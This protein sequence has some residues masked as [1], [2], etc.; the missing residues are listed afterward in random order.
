MKS[1]NK[2][3]K[4]VIFVFMIGILSY[5]YTLNNNNLKLVTHKTIGSIESI[6]F[7]Q[8]NKG[9]EGDNEVKFAM[10]DSM[11]N[12]ELRNVNVH[13]YRGYA[14]Y[15]PS[16]VTHADE[17][18]NIVKSVDSSLKID[19]YVITDEAGKV[20]NKLLIK[21]LSDIRK[22]NYDII[23]MSFFTKNDVEIT[24]YINEIYDKGALIVASA[25][26]AGNWEISYPSSLNNVI[27]IGGITP[28]G[29]IWENSNRGKIDYVMPVSFYSKLTYETI[30][31]TSISSILFSTLAI[32]LLELNPG[33][34]RD[35]LIKSITDI[36]I[37]PNNK[38][39]LGN[40]Q[41]CFNIK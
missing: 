29:D 22:K 16:E 30:Q 10:L 26:N 11:P 33:F 38:A 8:L 4:L 24:K 13:K 32:K 14:D 18:I 21:A 6:G 12:V 36:S 40:G 27:C 39:I 28:I 25:G 15:E 1:K 20:N 35:D 7:T 37:N 19:V 23:N 31:G 9:A 5:I 2:S 34:N 17:M 41:P 3:I